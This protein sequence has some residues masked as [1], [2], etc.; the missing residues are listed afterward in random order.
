[1]SASAPFPHRYHVCCKRDAAWL[2]GGKSPRRSAHPAATRGELQGSQ[3]S[4]AG[5]RELLPPYGQADE[6]RRRRVC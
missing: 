5:E 2:K 4:P 6:F 1:M 3:A